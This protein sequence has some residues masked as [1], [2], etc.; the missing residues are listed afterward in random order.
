MAKTKPDVDREHKR[1]EILRVAKRLFVQDGYDATS[2][3]RIASEVAVAP[4]TLYWYFA[5]KDA[6]LIAVLD[7]LVAEG[8][9]ELGRHKKASFE[10]QLHWLLGALAGAQTLITTVHSR[11]A[12][13]EPLRVWHDGF[14]RMLEATIEEQLRAAKAARGR[15]LYAARATMFVIEGLLAH[16]CPAKE[17][18]ALIK[19]L[20]SLTH[21]NGASA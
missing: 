10:S 17:Q 5:D 21:K 15:E 13:I 2:I 6:L 4:N 20:V 14:H 19:W 9:A 11:I 18:R 1:A 8:L 16:P 12:A 3:T 7:T